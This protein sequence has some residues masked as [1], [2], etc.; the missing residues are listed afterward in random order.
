MNDPK[1]T[2][3]HEAFSVSCSVEV[4][5][6]ARAESIWRLL[7]DA[8][9]FPRWN[10]TVVGIQGQIREGGRLRVRVPG[11]ERTFAPK[12]SGVVPCEHMVWTGGFAPVFKSVRT[13]QLRS[14]NDGSTDFTM[15]ER[16][17]GLMLPL[18]KGSLPDFGPI[19]ERY[20]NDLKLE[21]ESSA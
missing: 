6:R 16:F 19:F 15:Q 4:N 14:L 7:T 17:S 13:F 1:I 11:T 9:D 2:Q 12:V 21:A 20:A 18:V 8:D 3:Q 5:I 10:T